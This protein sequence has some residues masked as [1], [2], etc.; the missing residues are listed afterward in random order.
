MSAMRTGMA[1][2]GRWERTNA[3]SRQL[4]VPA[5]WPVATFVVAL[6]VFS[7]GVNRPAFWVDEY[8]TQLAVAQPWSALGQHVVSSD[9]GPGPYY[10]VMKIWSTASTAPGWLRLPSVLAAASAVVLVA[11][12]VRRMA[13]AV[14]GLLAAAVLLILPNVSRY[15]QENRPYAFA[16]LF[17]VLAVTLWQFSLERDSAGK[18]RSLRWSVGFGL[19]V[20][21]MGLAHLY[22]LTLLPALVIAAAVAPPADRRRRCL[23]TIVPAGSAVLAISPHI[24]LNLAHPTGSPTDPALSAGSVA[25]VIGATMPVALA[26]A[27]GVLALV[28]LAVGF[29]RPRLRSAVILASVW[30][31]VPLALLVLAKVSVDLPVTRVRYLLFVMPGVAILAALGLRHLAR[32]AAPITIFLLVLLALIG[33]PRQLAIRQV[34]GH[35]TDQALDP[36]MR[37]ARDLQVPVVAA[38]VQAVRFANAATYPKTLLTSSRSELGTR[39]VAVVER[40]AYRRTVDPDFP[41]YRSDRWRPVLRCRLPQSVFLVVENVGWPTPRATEVAD[42]I[43]RAT[44]RVTC[45]A[46]GGR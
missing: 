2:T 4:A 24:Y 28:G 16:L 9:P 7:V 41:Y 22:T 15:A 31:C 18:V 30:V 43:G 6:A 25:A 14:T 20:A 40:T 13:D 5:W 26:A 8:L 12:L 46:V 35:H 42:R 45:A 19:A 37:S 36:L 27:L 23:Q 11:V 29:R 10:L 38:H 1:V 3:A 21:A 44:S 17:C 34:D 33:L 39:H 32:L